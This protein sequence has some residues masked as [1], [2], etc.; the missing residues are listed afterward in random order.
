MITDQFGNRY[1]PEELLIDFTALQCLGSGH[2]ALEFAGDFTTEEE[3]TICQVFTDISDLII[4]QQSGIPIRIQK[5]ELEDGVLG[6]AR[7]FWRDDNTFGGCGIENN[8]IWEQINT[9]ADFGSALLQGY[10]TGVVSINSSLPGN[11]AWHTLDM[12]ASGTSPNVQSDFMD[13]YSVVLHEALHMLGF[14]SRISPDGTPRNGYYSTWDHFL[15]SHP[16]GA[17]LLVPFD[18]PDCC[19]AMQYNPVLNTPE[20]Y[21]FNCIGLGQ[22]AVAFQFGANASDQ[23]TVWGEYPSGFFDTP[24]ALIANTLSHINHDCD[25]GEYVMFSS[26]GDGQWRREVSVTEQN[27][28]CRLGYQLSALAGGCGPVC[29]VV[30][31]DDSFMAAQSQFTLNYEDI[32]IN[33]FVPQGIAVTVTVVDCTP[34]ASLAVDNDGNEGTITIDGLLPGQVHTLCYTLE[35]CGACDEGL[36]TIFR[37]FDGI[38]VGSA[39]PCG[40][41]ENIVPW[42]D[43]EAFVGSS[44]LNE[45]FVQTTLEV[46]DPFDPGTGNTPGVN[47]VSGNN[48]AYLAGSTANN[49]SIFL[50]LSQPIFPGCSI[51]FSLQYRPGFL[52][53][54]RIAFLQVY[55]TNLP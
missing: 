47:I 49:E 7:A 31:L 21:G 15:V 24:D 53:P 20:N 38:P 44:N 5:E 33:D 39:P 19:D 29:T 43:F 55:G 3:Q 8:L 54:D 9:D 16:D 23:A 30:G 26:I 42:G 28:L 45:Y 51:D 27:I 1:F 11:T 50:P 52:D 17:P 41:N 36:I 6:Q 22:E 4:S 37:A 14:A 2:F 46:C 25:G 12:D 48:V 10:V 32:L 35:G 13:L 34:F 18:D 40:N